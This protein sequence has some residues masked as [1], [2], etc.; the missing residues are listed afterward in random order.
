MS[1][2]SIHSPLPEHLA[3]TR[4][5]HQSQ[6]VCIAELVSA[7]AVSRPNAVAVSDGKKNLS[8]HELNLRANNLAQ[9]LRA[10]GVRHNVVVGLCLARSVAMVVGVLG[11]LKAGGAYLPLDPAYPAARLAFQLKDAQVPVVVTEQCFTER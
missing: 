1:I 5:K 6:A 11:I 10:L 2:S 3:T 8:Y 7:Q 9:H 4:S